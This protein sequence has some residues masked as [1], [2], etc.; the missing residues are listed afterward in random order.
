MIYSEKASATAA[1]AITPEFY[2]FVIVGAGLGGLTLARILQKHGM[3]V[4]IFEADIAR[5]A[6]G[7]GGSLDMHVESGQLALREAGLENAFR[8]IARPEGQGLRIVDKAGLVYWQESAD[9]SSTPDNFERPEVDRAKLRDLLLDSL[10]PGTVRWGHKLTA[11]EIAVS[12]GHLLH[13]DNGLRIHAGTLVGADG[14]WSRVRALLSDVNPHYTGV[15]FVEIGI[16]DAEHRHP[17]IAEMVGLGSFCALSDNKGL[18]AQRNGDGRIRIYIAL[19]L[20]EEALAALNLPLDQ[21][22]EA[23]NALLALF[24]DWAT[25]LTNLIRVCDDSFQLRPI[26]MLPVGLTWRSRPDVTVIG[27]AAHLMSPFA[28]EGANLAMLDAVELA[29]AVLNA[30]DYAEAISIYEAKMFAYSK[31]AAEQSDANLDLC[32]SEDGAKQ[33]AAL[34][35]EMNQERD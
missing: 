4:V 17:E 25:H 10:H 19:R 16:P 21:P 11:S 1:I 26:N 18:M 13:F 28:G 8:A 35:N 20:P 5:D 23:R 14:A 24:S 29:R 2:P 32:I 22:E 9:P 31:P 3:A 34:M 27:D 6:R 30:D 7:Q 15:S 12:G 33:M